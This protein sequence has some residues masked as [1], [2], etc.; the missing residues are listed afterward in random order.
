MPLSPGTASDLA[1]ALR[2][3][4]DYGASK[5]APA[6]SVLGQAVVDAR[7]YA[8]HLADEVAP[9]AAGVVIGTDSDIFRTTA[10]LVDLIAE[11]G[12]KVSPDVPQASATMPPLWLAALAVVGLGGLAY[13]YSRGEA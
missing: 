12:P 2:T 10:A 1:A 7:A 11:E 4:A 9:L 3:A 5:G 6:D 8:D 13:W